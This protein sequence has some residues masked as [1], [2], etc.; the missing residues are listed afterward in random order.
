MSPNRMDRLPSI[1]TNYNY[2]SDDAGPSSAS[3]MSNSGLSSS[4]STHQTI[5][6]P[7]SPGISRG[8]LNGSPVIPSPTGRSPQLGSGGGSRFGEEDRSVGGVNG[9]GRDDSSAAVAP[10]PPKKTNPLTDLIE[11][12]KDYVDDLGVIIKVGFTDLYLT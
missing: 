7:I 2:S 12:E 9:S 6:S 11:T 4:T 8:V 3:G 1:P 5:P 10:P